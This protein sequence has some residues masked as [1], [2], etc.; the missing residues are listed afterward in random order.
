[1]WGVLLAAAVHRAVVVLGTC[2]LLS[3]CLADVLVPDPLTTVGF[4]CLAMDPEGPPLDIIVF[5]AQG[6][7]YDPVAPVTALQQELSR[8]SGREGDRIGREIRVVSTPEGGWD[9]D[10]MDQWAGDQ[11]TGD[12]R[13]VALHVLW[14]DQA[15]APHATGGPIGAGKVVVVHD[16]V[17]A[18]AHATGAGV[19][20]V[21]AAVLLHHTGHALGMV[22]NGVPIQDNDLAKRENPPQHDPSPGSVMHAGWHNAKSMPNVTTERYGDEMVRDWKAIVAPEGMCWL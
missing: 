15:E 22:N 2:L 11:I 7:D 17:R 10:A 3:G 19:D 6:L 8:A 12:R 18:G 13:G 21:A 5:V 14:V 16:E 4:T 1:M 9:E 20:D